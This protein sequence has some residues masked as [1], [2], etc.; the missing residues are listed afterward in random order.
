MIWSKQ[1]LRVKLTVIFLAV[2]LLPM[3]A[4][5]AMSYRGVSDTLRRSAQREVR[6]LNQVSVQEIENILPQIEADLL[7]LV[8]MQA[9]QSLTRLVPYDETD[10]KSKKTYA[11][12]VSGLNHS[13][14]GQLEHKKLYHELRYLDNT[15]Q[16]VARVHYDGHNAS[17]VP[18]DAL[19]N[20]WNQPFF[21][22]TMRLEAGQINVSEVSLYRRGDE[23]IEPHM[24]IIR[25]STPIVDP[26]GEVSGILV[27]DLRAD[28]LLSRVDIEQ[29]ETYLVDQAGSYLLHPD[30][31]KRFGQELGTPYNAHHDFVWAMAQLQLQDES[32]FVGADRST[33][34][35]MALQT[36]QFDPAN[37]ER[38]WLLIRSLPTAMIFAEVQDWSSRILLLLTGIASATMLGALLLARN[39]TQ[40]ISLL[41]QASE[42]IA[43]GNW[44]TPLPTERNDEIGRLS[45]CFKDMSMRLQSSVETLKESESRYRAI[46]ELTSDYIYSI[47]VTADGV[48]ESSNQSMNWNVAALDDFIGYNQTELAERGGWKSIIHAADL[49]HFVEKRRH[50]VAT[51]E[52]CVVEYRILTKDGQT[53]WLQDYWRPQRDE[54]DG[55]IVRILG[56]ATDITARKEAEA[57]REQMLYNLW[58]LS[59]IM[60]NTSDFVGLADLAGNFI[61][62]NPAGQKMTG[63]ENT[64]YR[65][66]Q[67]HE[68]FVR[69]EDENQPTVME[70]VMREGVWQGET[71]LKHVDGSL[72]PATTVLVLVRNDAG[73]PIA[74]GGI[75]RDITAIK[76]AKAD[77]QAAK[78][79]AEAANRAK[80]EFLAN[81]SHELRT[82]LNGILGF[83]QIL[84]KANGLTSK[85]RDGLATIQRSGEH[86]L[87][88][89]NDVLD[90]SKV[91]AGKMELQAAEFDL[92]T[93]L[94]NLADMFRLRAEQ[95][96]ITFDYE[97]L[98]DLPMYVKADEKRLRQILINLLGNAV[99]F[100]HEG[101][102]AF[103]VGLIESELGGN[104]PPHPQRTIRFQVE[105]TGLG[106]A[107]DAIESIFL[108][109]Q[110]TGS[111]QMVEGTGLGLPISRQLVELMGGQLQVKSELGAGSTFWFEIEL[112]EVQGAMRQVDDEP[113]QIVGYEG[114]RRQALIVDDRAEN[115]AV[116]MDILAPLGFDMIEAVDGQEAVAQYQAHQPCLVL[117]DIR[118]PVMDGLAATRQ[119]RQLPSGS[120]AVIITI[121][122]SAFE[123]NRQESLDAGS[124]DFLAKPFR[125]ER[126]LHKIKAHLNLSWVY[127]KTAD[128]SHQIPNHQTNGYPLTDDG[129]CTLAPHEVDL[130]LDLA[131]RGN[132]HGIIQQAE[133][134]EQ[135]KADFAPHAAQL[136]QLAKAFKLK[137]LQQLIKSWLES[138]Q[139]IVN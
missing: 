26:A 55:R 65:L 87:T 22:E 101:G 111:G 24:A 34:H 67:T 41:T 114:V 91:E 6:L 98:T 126:L 47:D 79:A 56:A 60:E 139:L 33:D 20:A 100:T 82:P 76:Q 61:Y 14:V 39:I 119:I 63:R 74:I 44:N 59:A 94:D 4:M 5:L 28:Y 131:K 12:W 31:S 125:E 35:V 18:I 130:L 107:P 2:A 104:Q 109:F 70:V 92:P 90:I 68:V 37:P 8:D 77:L 64:D 57:E 78:D 81:M 108:P 96:A 120:E 129:P 27:L 7:S 17:V 54:A 1:R 16:E 84:R 89:I 50:M 83:A 36:I 138:R 102:V 93:M 128:G 132:I 48:V 42:R 133:A 75:S 9:I 99:K 116:L 127:E 52:A 118:M 123:H 95:Q 106:I 23:I 113:R 117:M 43:S 110:Q 103:K 15:G 105:D 51:G 71:C 21:S 134:L 62:F 66:L 25:Y 136:R 45:H 112:P 30:P 86:L 85:Q 19:Q 122:A 58:Q 38:H 10:L 135:E 49:P 40:P 53:H 73:E 69:E 29:G 11:M 13:F 115:R 46:S 88:L 80:S 124:N 72:I 121:S 3:A 97:L 32:Q 137:E